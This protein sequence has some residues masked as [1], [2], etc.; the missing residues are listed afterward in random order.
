MGNFPVSLVRSSPLKL[1]LINE[2][3]E[4]FRCLKGFPHHLWRT[5]RSLKIGLPRVHFPRLTV[6]VSSC[7]LY[8]SSLLCHCLP[9]PACQWFMS[10]V[11]V[12]LALP[13]DVRYWMLN[14]LLSIIFILLVFVILSWVDLQ[15][16]QILVWVPFMVNVRREGGICELLDNFCR[17]FRMALVLNEPLLFFIEN[18]EVYV[19]ITEGRQL[20]CLLKEPSLALAESCLFNPLVFNL[21]DVRSA[22]CH[23]VTIAYNIIL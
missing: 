18:N 2:L 9:F 20:D 11:N 7:L 16:I 8:F 19:L 15:I 6:A 22:L 14:S 3:V 5:P 17:K 4:L 10:S 12:Q 13:L 21:V 23:L 1:I